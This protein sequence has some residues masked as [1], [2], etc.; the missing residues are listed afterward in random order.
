V[1]SDAADG[2]ILSVKVIPRAGS[3]RLAGARDGAL[4][5]RLAA[6]PVEGAANAELI[7]FLA[8]LLD[9]PKRDVVVVS[10]DANRSKRVK[11][12]GLNAAQVRAR[13]GHHDDAR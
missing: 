9:L 1:I 11:V 5:I 4:L 6:A 7:A 10:G 3:T 12:M 8:R 2:A 13:L